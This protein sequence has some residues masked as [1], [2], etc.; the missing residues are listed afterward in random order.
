[1][2][3]GLLAAIITSSVSVAGVIG[4][5]SK[6]IC[7]KMGELSGEVRGMKGE[8]NGYNA[9]LGSCEKRF[10]SFDDRIS[11]IDQR[12]NGVIKED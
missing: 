9:R 8:M 5:G 12:I 7:M 1:M 10:D 6:W 4:A 11:R 2:D 3:G